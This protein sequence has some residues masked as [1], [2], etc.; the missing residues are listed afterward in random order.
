[1][2]DIG[3]LE[4]LVILVIALLVIGPER[5]P[6]LARKIGQFMGKMR[7]FV[8]SMKE[9]SQVQE[10]IREIHDSI[11]LEEEKKQFDSMGSE[12][13]KE[14]N[15]L[16]DINTDEFQRP[17]GGDINQGGSQFN[18]A[19]TQPNT[20]QVEQKTEDKATEVAATIEPKESS[21]NNSVDTTSTETAAPA[22][23]PKS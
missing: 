1:M 14:M 3:F 20:A 17:F 5:M 15:G 22:D 7:R 19:P 9:D 23:Q 21:E 11:N 16:S 2:F 13:E 4:L 18:R 6:E 10:T 12:L 8:N